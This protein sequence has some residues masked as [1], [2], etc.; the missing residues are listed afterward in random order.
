[1]VEELIVGSRE[2]S[3]DAVSVTPLKDRVLRV[4]FA[5]G[6]LRDFD[7]GPLL[8]RKCYRPLESDV[9]FQ[10]ARVSFG[11]VEWA[12]GLDIDPEWLYEDSVPVT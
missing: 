8:S 12:N 3:P 6:E 4:R 1:M 5:N 11:V 7:V 10:T 2:L 9:L